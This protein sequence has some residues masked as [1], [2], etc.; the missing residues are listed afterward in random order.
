VVP[1]DAEAKLAELS[2]LAADLERQVEAASAKLQALRP[3]RET[4]GG[5][6]TAA[7]LV[8]AADRTEKQLKR[9]AGQHREAQAM[10]Q[11]IG[12]AAV[13][14]HSADSAKHAPTAQTL[15]LERRVKELEQKLSEAANGGADAAALRDQNQQQAQQLERLQNENRALSQQLLAANKEIEATERRRQESERKL[16]ACQGLSQNLVGVLRGLQGSV[17]SLR[18]E[19]GAIAT[20]AKDER[21]SIIEGFTQLARSVQSISASKESLEVRCRDLAEERKKLHNLVLELKG[22]IRVFVRVRPMNDREKVDEAA[23]E[24]TISY[25]EDCKIS[26]YEVN[27]ARR[28]WF[29]F[30]KVFQPKCSQQEVFEEVTPLATSVLDG[31]NVCIFAYGQTGSG[32]TF[33]MT[34]NKENP[35]LNVRILTELFRI[36]ETRRAD[37]DISISLVITEIYNETI[38]DLFVTKQKKL[39]VKQNPDGSNTVPGLTELDVD[40]VEAVLKAMA[41]ASGNRTVMATDMNEESSRSHSIVQVRTVCVSK[42]DR[43]E[44]IGKINLIDLAG[45]ENVNKSG[46]TGQGMKEAQNINK[47]LS[48][49]GDVIQA[50]VAKTPHIPFR[51]SKLTMMLKDSLG[52]DC[53]TLMIVQCSPAQGNVV[54]TLSSLNF[55]ARARNVELGKAKRNV[56][57][58]D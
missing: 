26:V 27:T 13:G 57:G 52:G 29:D 42:K 38:K 6:P 43:R 16:K 50:L 14:V 24:S 48:A 22:N 44:Y 18:R 56:K 7:A 36:R 54:E 51:N 34:G 28:K 49:L 8:E 58:G 40:S 20:L 39:D 25:A 46:V 21:S 11:D 19:Q 23:G 31:Y 32:K 37:M 12:A 55:A 17:V 35:G 9:L 10:E 47:S 1:A 15:Q 45:S 5:T 3:S 4:N 33:T 2:R 30:D 53:K 41:E